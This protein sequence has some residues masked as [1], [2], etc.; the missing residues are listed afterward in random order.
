MEIQGCT[1]I[2]TGGASGLGEATSRALATAGARVGVVDMNEERL[3]EASA[4]IAKVAP[5]APIVAAANVTD[6]EA[7]RGAVAKALDATGAVNGV[8][9][10]AGITRDA[11]ISK[12]DYAD[13]QLVL[14]DLHDL[15]DSPVISGSQL[16]TNLL[17][18]QSERLS[19]RGQ[20]IDDLLR[21]IRHIVFNRG[22]TRERFEHVGQIDC[23]VF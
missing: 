22:N 9:N 14:A 10:V 19:A 17:Y 2:V 3:Q 5:V 11:R 8:V 18:G 4:E 13:F 15:S 6:E 23:G 20:L 7:V 12:K 1:A 16:Q 21:A